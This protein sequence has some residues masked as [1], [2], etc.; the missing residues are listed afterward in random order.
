[1]RLSFSTAVQLNALKYP[2]DAIKFPIFRAFQRILPAPMSD[3]NNRILFIGIVSFN[4][5]AASQSAK[6]SVFLLIHNL[7]HVTEELTQCTKVSKKK[8]WN[9]SH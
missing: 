5:K 1:M 4:G 9:E 8:N 6:I 3:N 2:N 7:T